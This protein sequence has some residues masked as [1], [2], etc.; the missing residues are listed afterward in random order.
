VNGSYRDNRPAWSTRHHRVR[1][2]RFPGDPVVA[3][4]RTAAGAAKCVAGVNLGLPLADAV[5]DGRGAD[6]REERP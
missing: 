6:E 2:R 5:R 4:F 1:D 3:E